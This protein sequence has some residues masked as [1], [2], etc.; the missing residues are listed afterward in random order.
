MAASECGWLIKKEVESV[1]DNHIYFR[2]SDA[3]K[4]NIPKNEFEPEQI[5]SEEDVTEF[6]NYEM[7]SEKCLEEVKEGSYC[8]VCGGRLLY[9]TDF[10]SPDNL[11]FSCIC[12]CQNES[13]VMQCENTM[14]VKT[15]GF[16]SDFG[17]SVFET[18]EEK[19][20]GKEKDLINGNVLLTSCEKKYTVEGVHFAEHEM[21]CKTEEINEIL[22]SGSNLNSFAESRFHEK[23]GGCSKNLNGRT[24]VEY[25]EKNHT[26]K[27]RLHQCQFCSKS[28]NHRCWLKKH[29]KIHSGQKPF[30]CNICSKSFSER[31]NLNIHEKIH[32]GEKPFHCKICSKSFNNS[33]N[34]KKH[35][36]IHSA[37]K[38]FKPFQCNICSKSFSHSDILKRHKIFHTGEKQFQCKICSKS[39]IQGSDLKKHEKIHSGEKLFQCKIC[40]KSFIT[41]HDLKRHE[42][43]HTGEKPFRCN[44]CSKS[45]SICGN[46]KTHE[47]IHTGEKPFRCNI[48][49][50]SFSL[51]GNLK[52]HEKIHT[53]E[54]PF[55]CNICSKTFSQKIHLK[56]HE[57]L[58]TDKKQC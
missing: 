34:L 14:D 35:E 9:S 36:K 12:Q 42:K 15:F 56:K 38:S 50:K 41:N 1:E 49:F 19:M 54:K 26:E 13:N 37:D 5:K 2:E 29:E 16:G 31:G 8:E 4:M 24:D 11:K 28:F 43:I 3:F 18:Q 53:A 6:V 48:C 47:K 32:T 39:F 51:C 57:K 27:I 58:H 7:K 33:S 21:S 55:Q 44:I 22:G 46:L 10:F 45:F 52:T 20:A 30:Q 17:T 23:T 25:F 40:S